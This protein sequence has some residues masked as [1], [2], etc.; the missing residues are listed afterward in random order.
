MIK[1]EIYSDYRKYKLIYIFIGINSII[2][3]ILL[4]ILIEMV[5][6]NVK[7][8]VKQIKFEFDESKLNKIKGEINE[9]MKKTHKK[10]RKSE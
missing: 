2:G 5:I 4:Y 7:H 10:K 9:A 8:S 1:N 6:K 3:F